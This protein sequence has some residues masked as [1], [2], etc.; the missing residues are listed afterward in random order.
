MHPAVLEADLT[1]LVSVFPSP[2]PATKCYWRAIAVN[3]TDR[4]VLWDVSL[5]VP[6]SLNCRS[7]A[8]DR[9]TVESHAAVAQKPPQPPNERGASGRFPSIL[10]SFCGEKFLALL[11]AVVRLKVVPSHW[12][13]PGGGTP[14]T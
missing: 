9:P 11:A 12:A 1:G 14:C 3:R 10:G 7:Q 5:P 6:P 8:G 13:A 4:T 2:E